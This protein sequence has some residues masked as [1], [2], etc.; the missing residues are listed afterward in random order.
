M[1]YAGTRKV[2][3]CEIVARFAEGRRSLFWS[4]E[5]LTRKLAIYD[6]PNL[7]LVLRVP[8]NLAELK[9]I[10]DLPVGAKIED[11]DTAFKA[12]LVVESVVD[13]VIC[14]LRLSPLTT[15]TSILPDVKKDDFRRRSCFELINP[16]ESVILSAVRLRTGAERALTSFSDSGAF[17]ETSTIEHILRKFI[18]NAH[19][20]SG[21]N[22]DLSWKHQII[23]G[24]LHSFVVLG[25]QS[26]LDLAIA[27][28]LRST[29]GA[30]KSNY[31][32]SRIIDGVD[33]SG[34][35][36]LHYACSSR[37]SSAVASLVKAGANVDLRIE[38]YNMTPCHICAKNLDNRSLAAVLSINK[39]PNV[40][41]SWGR[42]PMYLSITEGRTVGGQGGPDAL[43]RCLAVLESYGGEMEGAIG[44]RHPI[45]YLSSIWRHEELS[46]VLKHVNYRYPLILRDANDKKRIG[47]SVS[48][49]YQ[50][51]VHSSLITL[52]KRIK[53]ASEGQN[54]QQLWT[55]F[56]EPDNKLIK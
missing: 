19:K 24:T 32:D 36:P 30:E 6:D 43:D 11:P 31:L 2:A 51:P 37:F 16:V 7:I 34:R 28:A 44:F 42:T 23:L 18:C 14:K 38:P 20:P 53:S 56:A 1:A 25:N 8:D 35:T 40:V 48:A 54:V 13:P 49:F 55:E 41:D 4:D 45:S 46:A 21:E 10:M 29:D 9:E 5:Y 50:Y 15:A 26:F 39:R 17:L 12:Y 27:A 33:E 52:R 22:S 3:H 47:M